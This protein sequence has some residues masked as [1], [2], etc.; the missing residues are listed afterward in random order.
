MPS[1]QKRRLDDGSLSV[2]A[3]VRIKGFK[4]VS[5]A[6]RDE[7]E[8]KVW[9]A[10]TEAELK[11]QRDRGAGREDTTRMTIR[12]LCE[13]FLNDP[14]TLGLKSY[15]GLELLISWWMNEYGN[16]RVMGFG[17]T[18]VRDARD[19]LL[20]GRAPATVNRHLSAMRACWNW[21]RH[22]GLI[23]NESAW[24]GKV[25][26]TEPPGRARFLDDDELKKVLN[27]VSKEPA[28]FNAAV[29]VALGTGVRRGELLRLCWKDVDLEGQRIVVLETKN[30]TPRA[31]HLPGP[32]VRALK[33]LGRKHDPGERVFPYSDSYL[34]HT[35][36][37]L[38]SRISLKNFRF[39]DL[40]HTCASYLA[41][42]GASLLEIG[43]VLGHKSPSVTMRYAHL[44][45]GAP[46]AAHSKLEGKLKR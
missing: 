2:V 30:G 16:E 31:V 12:T 10:S 45:Q 11:R 35:W 8:A 43:S 19:R 33:A 46:L 3:L 22:A 42:G 41:Q 17:V 37:A 21:G 20:P 6:F 29:L 26:L 9:A 44:V 32:A 24:P 27:A 4:P 40:R 14:K 5:K 38:M 7:K 15:D 13:N 34:A 28:W 23:A 39:H 18:K 36:K 25:M 1:F